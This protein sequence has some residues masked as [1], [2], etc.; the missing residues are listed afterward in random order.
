MFARSVS[1]DDLIPI[2]Q[3]DQISCSNFNPG[4]VQSKSDNA[5]DHR[6]EVSPPHDEMR[7]ERE[8]DTHTHRERKKED[9]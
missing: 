9:K 7:C 8:R 1:A 5:T 2:Q 3:R 6:S 4:I